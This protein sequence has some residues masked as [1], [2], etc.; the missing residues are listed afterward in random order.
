MVF[1][2]IFTVFYNLKTP[3]TLKDPKPFLKVK[4]ESL[5]TLFKPVKD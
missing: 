5:A 4:F 3:P 2:K 1:K